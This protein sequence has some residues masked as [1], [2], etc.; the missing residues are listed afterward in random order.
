MGDCALDTMPMGWEAGDGEA[1]EEGLVNQE[2]EN[3]GVLQVRI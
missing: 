3:C 2:R 1:R